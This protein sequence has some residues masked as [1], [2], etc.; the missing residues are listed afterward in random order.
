AV[1]AAMPGVRVVAFGHIGDG[2]IHLNL[3]Q[4]EG[5]DKQAFLADWARMNKIVHDIVADMDGS[6][7]AEHGIG[8]LKIEEMARYKS[9]VEL[10][11]MQRIKAALDPQGIMN[12]GKV[13]PS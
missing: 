4:P 13:L 1:E 9:D 5:A 2:N 11:L 8:Q 10:D 3:T 12:P 6:V 7:S